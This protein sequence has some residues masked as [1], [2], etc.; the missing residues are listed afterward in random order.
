DRSELAGGET[1]PSQTGAYQLQWR[2]TG[3]HVLI[4]ESGRNVCHVGLVKHTVAVDGNP[5]PVAGI[6]GVLTRPECRG[7]G[8]ARIAMKAAEAFALR[9]MEVDF[10]LLFCRPALQSWYEG[11]GWIRVSSVVWIEQQQRTIVQPL[12]SMVRCLGPKQW[13]LGE[14]RLGCLPW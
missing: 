11:R 9:Q 3:K 7:R 12:V 2:P 10:M 13:P 1:D 6:G 14:V 8:Y 5:V 4:V